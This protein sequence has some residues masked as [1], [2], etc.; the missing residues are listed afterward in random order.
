M[1]KPNGVLAI[2]PARGGSKSIPRKNIR[3]LGGVPLIGYSI[4]AGRQARSVDRVVVSTDDDEIADVA[5]RCGADVPFMRPPE[6]A[7]D[8]SPD[9]PLLQHALEWLADEE[10]YHPEIIVQLR[11]TSPF[12]PPTCVDDAVALLRADPLADSVRTVVLS[13][14]NPYKMWRLDAGGLMRPLIET[15]GVEAYNQPRQSL[16]VTHWQT[17]HVDAI[18]SVTILEDASVSGER[19]RGF[20]VPAAYSCDIDTDEDWVRA[21]WTLSR[22][23]QPL[24]RPAAA[25]ALP[26]DLRL[27][28]FDFDGVLTDNRVWVTA[29]GQEWVAGNRSD[30]I[31]L[32]AV[33]RLGVQMLVLSTETN[34]VVSERC[35]KLRLECEQGIEDKGSRLRDILIAR[36]LA[37]ASVIYVGNDANDIDCMR[38]VGCAVAVGDAHPS[39]LAEA[40]IVLK[41]HGGHGA[42]RELCDAVHAH[43]SHR[44][45]L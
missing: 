38:L 11:P 16:P 19:I 7:T 34:P 2:V 26:R 33:R 12:R 10:G 5:R 20:E 24:V 28:V 32:A 22:F 3:R 14:Q 45:T 31:G 27:I 42:V 29:G 44:E 35:R 23:V 40:D 30:G 4:E 17:G 36:G 37:P 6:L 43:L 25:T 41:A 21:E 9:L 18:R 13:S 1:V 15:A 8:R 39:A